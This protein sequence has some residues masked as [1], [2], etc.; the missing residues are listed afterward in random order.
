MTLGLFT[1]PGTNRSAVA[2]RIGAL[3][4]LLL[5]GLLQLSGSLGLRI[6][7]SPSLPVGLYITTVD[8]KS[9]LVEFCPPEPYAR[10]AIARGYRDAGNCA[11]GAAP[12][13][14]PVIA[15]AGD[16]VEVS[17]SGLIVN[18]QPVPNTAAVHTDTKGRPLPPWPS[19]HYKVEAGTI[20]VAS[21]YN[22]RSFDSRYFGPIAAWTI[23]DRVRPLITGG[24]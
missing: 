21:S 24:K 2:K 3:C 1:K 7:T 20:W 19:G 10:F 12:L 17:T 5:F 15:E 22:S 8:P 14:K 4:L 6:N 23:R 11:D 16:V 13:L 9:R 18:G